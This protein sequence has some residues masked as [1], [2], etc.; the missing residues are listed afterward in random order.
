MRDHPGVIA[1]PPLIALGAIGAGWV[2]GLALPL[3]LP[4]WAPWPGVVLALA[5]VTLALWAERIFKA[6]GTTAMPWKPTTAIAV[7][8]PYR[9]SRNPMYLGLLAAQLGT[10]LILREGWVVLLAAAT[11][12]ALHFGVVL[13][14]ER[15]LSAK[16]GAEYDEYR[17]RTRRW[18]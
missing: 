17:A 10:G 13:R 1:P 7:A 6:A 2:L 14:E 5:G 18:L 16:F 3:G 11:L 12:A 15:Y 8:G 4:A 9:F